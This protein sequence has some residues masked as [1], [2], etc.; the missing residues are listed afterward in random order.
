MSIALWVGSLMLF[1]ILYY[2]ASDRF[3]I[4]SRNADNKLKRTIAYILLAALQGITLGI[5]LM[6]GLDFYNY[7]LFTYILFHLIVVTCL[8]E[9]IMELLMTTF[10]DIGKFISLILLSITISGSWWYIPNSNSYKRI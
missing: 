2:D 10:G 4:L 1:I 9:S 5:L 8:F 6:I 3:K 7:K